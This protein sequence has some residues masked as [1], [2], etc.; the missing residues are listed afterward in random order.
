M[1]FVGVLEDT[2]QENGHSME[3]ERIRL[4]SSESRTIIKV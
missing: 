3:M 4:L 1:G 2:S